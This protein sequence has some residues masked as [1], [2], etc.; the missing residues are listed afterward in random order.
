M[1]PA[2]IVGA[3]RYLGAPAG[4]D[5]DAQ[6]PCASLAIRDSISDGLPLME[7]VW[8][9]TPDQ[10][11]ALANGAKVLLCVVGTAHPMV[12]LNVTEPPGR[13]R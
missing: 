7:S 3:T 2:R 8:E 10:L 12:A 1:I 4:Y 9:P 11:D 13:N 6:P 5:P